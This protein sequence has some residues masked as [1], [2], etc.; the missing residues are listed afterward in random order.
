MRDRQGFLNIWK[1]PKATAAAKAI[2]LELVLLVLN[3]KA[4]TRQHAPKYDFFRS[5]WGA[6]A[7]EGV[8]FEI[9]QQQLTIRASCG[10]IDGRQTE[11]AEPVLELSARAE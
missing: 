3:Q 7:V 10:D 2:Q 9:F 5:S 4:S 8:S 11:N 6:I 1:L